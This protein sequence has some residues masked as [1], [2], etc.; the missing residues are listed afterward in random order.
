MPHY[1]NPID[2]FKPGIRLE[3]VTRARENSDANIT[4]VSTVQGGENREQ[5][6]GKRARRSH[7]TRERR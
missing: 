2:H 6:P 4:R 7:Y 1:R 3:D 5:M